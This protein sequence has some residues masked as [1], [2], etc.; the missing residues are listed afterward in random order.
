MKSSTVAS[1]DTATPAQYNN[2]R[3]DAKI[4][5][6]LLAH[7]QATPDMTLKIEAGIFYMGATRIVYAGGNTPSFTAPTTN[8]RIDIVAM[9]F[10]GDITILQGSEAASPVPPTYL[11]D[12][13]V[14]CEVY[15]RVG[16]T[17]IKDS[18]DSSNGYIYRDVRQFAGMA[19]YKAGV[20]TDMDTG[21][22]GNNDESPSLLF[23]PKL[24]ILHYFIQGRLIAGIETKKGIAVFEATSLRF[25]N[26]LAT[27]TTDLALSTLSIDTSLTTSPQAGDAAG[28][29][30]IRIT[31]SIPAVSVSG[32]TLRRLTEKAGTPATNAKCRLSWEA[33]G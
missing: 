7:E 29:D 15:H 21:D 27:G 20:A 3:E 10:D 28:G 25:N 33:F 16:E 11:L 31:L 18:D 5:A 2:L 19:C 17:S 30:V 1:G 12:K 6:N 32:F 14:I 24:I 26:V 23:Q 9:R 4:A 8:P 13:F 22:A